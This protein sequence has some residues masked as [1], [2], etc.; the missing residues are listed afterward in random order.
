MGVDTKCAAYTANCDDWRKVR[1]TIAGERAIRDGGV[2]YLPRPSG[3]DDPEWKCYLERAHFFGATGRTADGL[4]GSVFQKKPVLSDDAPD[5]LKDML[6]DIDRTGRTLDQFASDCVWDALPTNWGGILVDYPSAPDNIDRGTAERQGL[7]AYA[8][9]YSA[10]SVINWRFE[11]R[12]NQQVLTFLVLHEPY[13]RK[14]EGDEFATETKNR[15]RVLSFDADGNYMVRIYDDGTTND[16]ATPSEPVFPKVAGKNLK[17]I[18]FFTF[19]G[20]EPEK[21][22][23]LDLANENIGHYQK[24]ADY[25][26]G[27][28]LTG[29]PTP[30][31]TG[32]SGPPQDKDGKP[33]PIK[34]GGTAFLFVPDPSGKVEYLEFEGAGLEQLE[35]AIQNTEERMAILGARIISAEKKGVE[36]AE[37][38]RIH[39]AGE[40]SVLAAFAQNASD[41]LTKVI[42]LL[43]Q[44]ENIPGCEKVTYRL[45]TEYDVAAMEANLFS[46]I[47]QARL[48]REMPKSVY[49]WN[50]KKAGKIP[51]EMTLE[52]WDEELANEPEAGGVN[53]DS[54]GAGGKSVTTKGE[55]TA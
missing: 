34:L 27:L 10:E 51:D 48:A 17:I 2:K 7:R 44:W 40:N 33:L 11:T 47:V 26:N 18:P 12:G 25:E 32:M 36:S 24:S 37:A 15:Y 19:P 39:R 41:V 6:A 45:N 3:M 46:A 50:L 53:G 29:I 38:A 28:H 20:K 43:A 1:D 22:M 23:L 35:K 8:A 16:L 30:Y 49:F 54:A 5:K 52:Q 14:K 13:T 55:K 42:R 21:S 31:A 4:H 9:W